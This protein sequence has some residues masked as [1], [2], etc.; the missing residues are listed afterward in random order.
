MNG[1]KVFGGRIDVA[2]VGM[3][4]AIG[5]G[6]VCAFAGLLF[7]NTKLLTLSFLMLLGAV[8]W[9]VLAIRRQP[10]KLGQELRASLRTELHPALREELRTALGKLEITPIWAPDDVFQ[11]GRQALQEGKW[12]RVYI[13]APVG[14]WDESDEKDKWLKALQKALQDHQITEFRA[15]YGLPP[16]EQLLWTRA[17][18]RLRLFRDTI[19]TELH[20]LPPQDTTAAPG[21]G[22]IIFENRR[23]NRYKVIFAFVGQV[24]EG[25]FVRS[26]IAIQNEDIVLNIAGWF[27]RQ[28]FDIKNHCYVLRGQDPDGAGFAK[29]DD[30]LASIEQ[31]Y[32]TPLNTS[33]PA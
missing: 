24:I 8:A 28:L 22:A 23:E 15:F 12:N 6:T 19:P 29:F 25:G 18:E 31:R 30:V 5:A 32:Y 2:D 11:Q 17:K 33:S 10:A 4:I 16:N 26:G 1:R 14:L 27:D 7:D 9:D 13:Y 3:Y 20:Y 21:L